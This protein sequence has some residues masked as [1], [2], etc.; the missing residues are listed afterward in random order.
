[1]GNNNFGA[2]GSYTAIA[3]TELIS[4]SLFADCTYLTTWV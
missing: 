1:M 4:G 3:L 2:Y